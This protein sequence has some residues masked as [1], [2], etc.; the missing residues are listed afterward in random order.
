MDIKIKQFEGPLDLLLQMIEEQKMD[1]TEVSLATVA[2][3]YVERIRQNGIEPEELADFLVIAAKLLL[4]KSKT[5]LPYLI[6]DEEEQEI[7]DFENQLKVYKDFLEAAKK[8]ESLLRERHFM[9]AREFNK[10]SLLEEKFFYPP[11]NVTAHVLRQAFKELAGRLQA[12]EE[13]EEETLTKVVN[14]E[15][16]MSL[17]Q[18]LL[19]RLENLKFSHLLEQAKSRMEI[20]VSFLA[21]L[22]LI[23]QRAVV[24]NQA[25][26]FTDITILKV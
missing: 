4:I 5:L 15:E 3:Q 26:L 6:H 24:V 20:V 9:F 10:K 14:I 8:V 2:D 16:K 13:L 17:I 19:K 11:K 21:M 18:S 7:K 23:K 12:E 25:E 1:I 22:E